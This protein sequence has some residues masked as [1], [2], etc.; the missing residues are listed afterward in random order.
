MYE[1]FLLLGQIFK[2]VQLNS[3]YWC[4]QREYNVVCHTAVKACFIYFCYIL[5]SHAVGKWDVCSFVACVCVF[6]GK[7]GYIHKMAKVNVPHPLVGALRDDSAVDR[8]SFFFFPLPPYS[9][10]FWRFSCPHD[11]DVVGHDGYKQCIW[12]A[13]DR[14]HSLCLRKN[15]WCGKV[16]IAVGCLFCVAASKRM[17]WE[18]EVGRWGCVYREVLWWGVCG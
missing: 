8:M 16:E 17:W 18:F 4:W 12:G 15:W 11:V 14:V 10:G 9:D 13:K 3:K 7:C 5:W 2:D 1:L 6:K